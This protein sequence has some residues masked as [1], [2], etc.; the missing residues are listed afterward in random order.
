MHQP[1]T[2]SVCV[3]KTKPKVLIAILYSSKSSP[4]TNETLEEQNLKHYCYGLETG[5]SLAV[6]IIIHTQNEQ[7]IQAHTLTSIKQTYAH[8]KKV[9]KVAFTLKPHSNMQQ[10]PYAFPQQGTY[11]EKN[12]Y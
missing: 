7:F 6:L 3:Y 8:M 11:K 12:S 5:I 9:A 10:V 1:C 4:F 2:N